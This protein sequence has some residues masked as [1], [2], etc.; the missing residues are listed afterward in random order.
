MK[1]AR[2]KS[3]KRVVRNKVVPSSD[4]FEARWLDRKGLEKGSEWEGFAARRGVC[5]VRLRNGLV[6]GPCFAEGLVMRR[7]DGKNNI[8]AADVSRVRYYVPEPEPEDVEI[9]EADGLESVE[10][11]EMKAMV[12]DKLE[13]GEEKL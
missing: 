4:K 5:E 11:M 6:V 9:G 7:A 8:R 12:R 10:K 3:K 2:V 13:T 1:K